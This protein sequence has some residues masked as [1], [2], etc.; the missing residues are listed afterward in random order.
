MLIICQIDWREVGVAV[1]LQC[2]RNCTLSS[3]LLFQSWWKLLY[4]R[5]VCQITVVFCEFF[6][7]L[8]RKLLDGITLDRSWSQTMWLSTNLSESIAKT[9]FVAVI[10]FFRNCY[11]GILQYW[12][13]HSTCDR[14]IALLHPAISLSCNKSDQ[15]VHVCVVLAS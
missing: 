12:I 15:V 13:E 8:V 1:E 9:R 7:Q 5:I 2:L 4:E 10:G 6:V 3:L 11:F 14:G